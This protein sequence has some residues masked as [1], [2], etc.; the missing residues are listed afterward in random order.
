MGMENV[1]AVR[2][3]SDIVGAPTH[4][5]AATLEDETGFCRVEKV[6]INEGTKPDTVEGIEKRCSRWSTLWQLAAGV[7]V[8]T[9]PRATAGRFSELGGA[10]V[11]NWA[12]N[13]AKMPGRDSPKA[14]EKACA[15]TSL[16]AESV[17]EAPDEE[18][19]AEDE[20]ELPALA[21]EV[22]TDDRLL[23]VERT[24]LNTRWDPWI[25]DT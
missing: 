8:T 24:I 5:G 9:S 22:E 20:D 10:G 2:S 1:V 17:V 4:N 23:F 6:E 11:L 7:S 18:A 3:Q 25:H 15:K 19:T 14:L 13:D 16:L 21:F 12:W